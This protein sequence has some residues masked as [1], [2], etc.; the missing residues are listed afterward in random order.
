MQEEQPDRFEA[1]VA[2][3]KADEVTDETVT[4]LTNQVIK[5]LCGKDSSLRTDDTVQ[6]LAQDVVVRV[7]ERVGK[8]E[9]RAKAKTWLYS[10]AMN[11][12]KEHWKKQK[13]A[14]LVPLD[15][16]PEP[17]AEDDPEGS[18]LRRMAGEDALQN[19][20]NERERELLLLRLGEGLSFKE[21]AERLG[22]NDDAASTACRRAAQKV[23]QY[24]QEQ[25]YLETVGETPS[26]ASR[27]SKER[28]KG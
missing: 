22:G 21:I 6:D 23:R 11:R 17:E 10:F 7:Y 1:L 9:G 20:L 27:S 28:R 2:N 12:L 16:A 13:K 19:A 8:F 5:W 26:E 14:V 3:W 15:D 18:T 24:L 4:W 25:G